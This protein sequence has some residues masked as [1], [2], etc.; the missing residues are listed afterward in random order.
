MILT[1]FRGLLENEASTYI[2]SQAKWAR[3]GNYPAK[4]K[5]WAMKY[6]PSV[7]SNLAGNVVGSVM[8]VGTF[9]AQMAALG[10]DATKNM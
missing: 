6:A 2:G 4:A 9:G 3:I 1:Y 7:V 8:S 10:Y 5:A